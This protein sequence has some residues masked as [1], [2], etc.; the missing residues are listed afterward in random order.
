MTRDNITNI[1]LG[2]AIAMT[3]ITSAYVVA[4]VVAILPAII[5]SITS[6]LPYYGTKAYYN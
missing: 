4:G 6:W 2:Y 5:I 3:L 1:T